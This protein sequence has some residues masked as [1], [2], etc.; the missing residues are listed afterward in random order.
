MSYLT[1]RKSISNSFY[2][3]KLL[4]VLLIDVL[5]FHF[6]PVREPV[7]KTKQCRG[8][9]LPIQTVR[10]KEKPKT[11]GSCNLPQFSEQPFSECLLGVKYHAQVLHIHYFI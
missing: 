9:F 6:T 5:H 10:I 1:L 11:L 7:S 4:K 3:F 8:W 2:K